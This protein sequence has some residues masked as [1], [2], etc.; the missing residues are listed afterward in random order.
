LVVFVFLVGGTAYYLSS[1][2][3][4]WHHIDKGLDIEGGFNVELVAVDTPE[5][6]VT[7]DRMKTAVQVIQ[8][9]V[10]GLG[11]K[12]PTIRR[13]GD[14]RI[15]LELP[16]VKDPE[17]ALDAIGR[18]AQLEFVALPS[19]VSQDIS[20]MNQEEFQQ[21][22]AENGNT[23]LTGANLKE[24]G[25]T[26]HNVSNKPLVS[27]EFDAEG[28]RKFEEATERNVGKPLFIMLDKEIISSPQVREP[29]SGGKAVIEGVGDVDQAQELSV[30]LNS[31]ALPVQL[32][33]LRPRFV[34]ALL[35]KD[36]ISQSQ[37]AAL[38]GVA[39]VAAFMFLLYRIPGIWAD[40]SLAV[41][42]MLLLGILA[43]I[44]AVLT[45]PGIAGIILTIGMAVD[46]NVLIF[47]RIRDEIRI[48]KTIRSAVD[49]GFA[50]AMRAIIDGNVTTLIIAGVLFFYFR[51]G[52]LR[53]FAVT[54]SIGILAS[55]FTAITVT[56]SLLILMLGTGLVED[57]AALFGVRRSDK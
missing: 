35:G 53:G 42:I 8:R 51:S 18:T 15:V 25:V 10:D 7:D 26:F 29:I 55:M 22:L 13:K 1:I 39:A 20:D 17:E 9:R 36:S 21:W 52:P 32:E 45:L 49:S 14:R 33:V 40:V 3:P 48:G 4:I 5:T 50:N 54:L 43:G 46:A 34:S 57:G 56:R 12:E 37:S 27:L 44:N 47:E 19:E 6:P 24:A 2:N 23:V 30:L 41:Y 38:I 28:A 31:G 16:G 11:V